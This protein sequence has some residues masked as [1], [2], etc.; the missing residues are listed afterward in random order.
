V[1]QLKSSVKDEMDKLSLQQSDSLTVVTQLKSSVKDEMD[2]LSLQQS[3]SLTVV[4]QLKSSVK[5]EMDKLSLQQSDS[6][7]VV[8]QL[9]SS[10]KDE[11]N[12]LSL[13]QSDSL[14]VVSQLK[15]SVEDE[16][17]KLYRQQSSLV[18]EVDGIVTDKLN[19]AS[20]QIRSDIREDTAVEFRR[21]AESVQSANQTLLDRVAVL[22]E[23]IALQASKA[24]RI[25]AMTLLLLLALAGLEG[26]RLIEPLIRD[27]G[28]VLGG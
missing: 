14:T 2:K 21:A 4:T 11:M 16:M 25:G 12:K 7:T 24:M 19:R 1:T 26:W 5:D 9:K 22:D 6:L 17:N 10:V 27:G 8:T 13:Q 15:A 3:D 23:T 20:A 18:R 28:W